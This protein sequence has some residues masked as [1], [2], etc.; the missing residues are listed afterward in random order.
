MNADKSST[1]SLKAIKDE[2]SSHHDTKYIAEEFEDIISLL[3]LTEENCKAETE[4][5]EQYGTLMGFTIW[6]ED[7]I[8]T[9]TRW[10]WNIGDNQYLPLSEV[11]QVIPN[12]HDW[13]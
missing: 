9:T 10:T 5:T 8:I 11:I 4:V 6:A 12:H 3:G 13:R 1:S 2:L 7:V